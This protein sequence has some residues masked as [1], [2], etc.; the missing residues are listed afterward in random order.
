[1][2]FEIGNEDIEVSKLYHDI[3]Y[4]T[5]DQLLDIFLVTPPSPASAAFE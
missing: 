1:M 4:H 3:K 5:I 2:N